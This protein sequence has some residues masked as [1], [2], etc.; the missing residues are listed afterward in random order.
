MNWIIH[1]W[2][3]PKIMMK[4]S[5]VSNYGVLRYGRYTYNSTACNISAPSIPDVSHPYQDHAFTQRFRI[6][7]YQ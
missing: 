1:L 3:S 4:I 2:V 7:T 5:Q 6:L